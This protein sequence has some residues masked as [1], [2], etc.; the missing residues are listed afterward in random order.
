MNM[1]STFISGDFQSDR[2]M[3]IFKMIFLLYFFNFSSLQ[4]KGYYK[5]TQFTF[6]RNGSSSDTWH[7]FKY[8]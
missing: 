8:E 6:T 7:L 1:F 5:F 3:M 2:A 4:Q